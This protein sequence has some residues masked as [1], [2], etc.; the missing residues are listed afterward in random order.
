MKRVLLVL[1]LAITL[2]SCEQRPPMYPM[3][4][5]TTV[6]VIPD[7]LSTEYREYVIRLVSAA[8]NHMSAGD[9]EDVDVTIIQA[10]RTA[11]DLF[12]RDVIG[13]TKRINSSHWDNIE[14]LEKDFN[15]M[16][17]FIFHKL[18]TTSE[19]RISLSKYQK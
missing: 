15:D 4:S 18:K 9:Y 6:K 12:S 2:L 1:V 7:S 19:E 5:L 10:K 8:S 11:D 3:Y 14:I 17:I 16:E 13:L